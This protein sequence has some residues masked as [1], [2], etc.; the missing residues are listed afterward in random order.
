MMWAHRHRGCV[1]GLSFKHRLFD[2]SKSNLAYA[3]NKHMS[4]MLFSTCIKLDVSATIAADLLTGMPYSVLG[5]TNVCRSSRVPCSLRCHNDILLSRCQMFLLCMATTMCLH[6]HQSVHSGM[7]A[8]LHTRLRQE[9]TV[10]AGQQLWQLPGCYHLP[11]RSYCQ[12]S[13]W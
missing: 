8:A 9:I 6:N 10:T 4:C 1:L 12:H 13:L 3:A 11:A 2:K 7:V 5:V